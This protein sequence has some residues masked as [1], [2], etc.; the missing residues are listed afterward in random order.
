MSSVAREGHLT[1]IFS[2]EEVGFEPTEPCGSHAFQAWME[3]LDSAVVCFAVEGSE[4]CTP[5]DTVSDRSEWL[6]A[7][8]SVTDAFFVCDFAAALIRSAYA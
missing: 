5:D 1:R 4:H 3:W 8:L 2:A 7:W 6:S